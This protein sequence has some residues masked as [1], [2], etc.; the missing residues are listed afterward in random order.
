MS[1]NCLSVS[2]L[3]NETVTVSL[4]D[5][6]LRAAQENSPG[7]SAA[8]VPVVHKQSAAAKRRTVSFPFSASSPV[9]FPSD[10]NTKCFSKTKR[11]YVLIY[12]LKSRAARVELLGNSNNL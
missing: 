11:Q 12:V 7:T 2:P 5:E 8:D 4:S 1:V 10:F 9:V 6:C 3:V